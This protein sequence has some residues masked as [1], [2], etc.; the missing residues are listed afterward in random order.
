MVSLTENDRIR[1]D[2]QMRIS[3]WGAEGQKRLKRATVGIIGTGGLGS[4]ITIYLAVAGVGRIVLA[5]KDVV[6]RSNLNRQI[7]HWDRDIGRKKADSAEEKLRQLNPEIEIVS[8]GSEITGENIEEVFGEV[9]AV[10][11]ALDNLPSRFLLNEFA[12]RHRL[13]LF[14]GAVWGL[15][16]R[17]STMIPGKTVCLRC[18]YPEELPGEVFP[19]A[20]VAPGLIGI[21]QATEVL[22]YFTGV[23]ELLLNQ[24]LICD[25]ETMSFSK[26]SLKRTPHCP[27]CSRLY[28]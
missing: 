5:D 7:L 13:P 9:D 18:I 3:G 22:K 14:H 12:I 2:R 19:V 1:F 23:G 15:E 25:A 8:Y 6:E 16:G 28:P 20:G 17:A 24:L 4:P 11:D 27:V 10:V 21:I 26:I